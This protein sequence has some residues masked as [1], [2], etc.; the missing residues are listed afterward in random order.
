MRSIIAVGAT[1]AA[2]ARFIQKNIA[3]ICLRK[4]RNDFVTVDTDEM[5]TYVLVH[6]HD[7]RV[8]VNTLYDEGFL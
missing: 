6:T 7:P 2:H 1:S 4:N 8:M 3:G 5:G